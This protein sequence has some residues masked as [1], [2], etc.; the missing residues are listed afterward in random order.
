MRRAPMRSRDPAEDAA[1]MN[2]VCGCLL[3]RSTTVN[4]TRAARRSTTQHRIPSRVRERFVPELP[5][6]CR[7]VDPGYG[8]LRDIHSNGSIMLDE[9]SSNA[10]P[11]PFVQRRTVDPQLEARARDLGFSPVAARV[12]GGRRLASAFEPAVWLVPSLDQLD[13]EG[14]LADIECAAERLAGAILSEEV[15]GIATDYDMDGLGAHA[16]FRLALVEMFGHPPERLRSYV[17]H[18]LTEGYGLT[19]ALTSRILDERPRPALLVSADCG[20]SDEERIAR[21]AAAGI[22]VIVTDHHELP[23]DGPPRS[24]YACINPQRVDCAY[25]DKAI[26]GGMVLWLLLRAVR[27]ILCEVGHA[28]AQHAELEHLLDLVACSTVADCVSLAGHNNRAVVRAGLA[29]MNASTRPCWHVA[30][31]RLRVSSFQAQ[32]IAFG[33]APR[34]N[35]R[36]RLSDP[37]AALHFLLARDVRRAEAAFDVLDAENRARKDIEK[38]MLDEAVTLAARQVDDGRYAITLRLPEGHPGVQGDL[39]RATGGALR[40]AD[41]SLLAD[42]R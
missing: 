27:K 37:F 7:F 14:S 39:Q 6:P 34:V 25:P 41:V 23:E 16:V 29:L 21:L 5:A 33:I 38:A 35:A 4:A 10:L 2:L 11:I 8:R 19:A 31:Q 30:A 12:L 24:A 28:P 22:D 20:S 40:P 42:A 13:D 1:R 26:A 15:I 9:S 32:T 36:S 18:R 17:G 3:R